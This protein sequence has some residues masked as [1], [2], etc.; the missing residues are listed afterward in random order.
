M[1]KIL[2]LILLFLAAPVLAADEEKKD[3]NFFILVPVPSYT[4]ETQWAAFLVGAYMFRLD[5]ADKITPASIVQINL[6]YTQLNQSDAFVELDHYWKNNEYF[7]K[8]MLEYKKYPDRLFGIGNSPS[9]LRAGT[10]PG[11]KYTLEYE[12]I[13][14]EFYKKI[15]MDLHLG[16]RWLGQHSVMLDNE[17]P[18]YLPGAGGGFDS[19]LAVLAK[20]DTRDNVYY[21]MSGAYY[22]L[23]AMFFGESIGSTHHFVKW[24]IDL[25]HYFKINETNSVSAQGLLMAEAGDPPFYFMNMH[26]GDNLL[27]GYFAGSYRDRCMTAIQAEY[28]WIFLPRFVAAAFAGVG[29]VAPEITKFSTAYLLWSAGLGL[30]FF[31]DEKDRMTFRADLGFGNGDMGLY[32]VAAEAF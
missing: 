28:K 7:L 20:W 25:R 14:L 26:G 19:G 2:V 21:A 1:K 30:R 10:D 3:E 17:Y 29:T 16:A 27:R 32:L 12:Y 31:L 24:D 8:M 22:Q 15:W 11:Y 18:G 13:W 5:Q 4:P 6:A 23:A 9:H